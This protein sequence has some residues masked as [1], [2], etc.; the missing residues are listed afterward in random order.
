LEIFLFIIF[1][2]A[3]YCGPKVRGPG[4]Q[5]I[6]YSSLSPPIHVEL[7]ALDERSAIVFWN[8]KCFNLAFDVVNFALYGF[9]SFQSV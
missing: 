9:L 4:V 6:G 8:L 7:I 3:L 5:L 1:G 2:L